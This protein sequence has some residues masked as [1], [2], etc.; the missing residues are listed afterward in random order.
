MISGNAGHGSWLVAP[1][2]Q[3]RIR[4]QEVCKGMQHFERGDL[5]QIRHLIIIR[6]FVFD[7]EMLIVTVSIRSTTLWA[8]AHMMIRL[9]RLSPVVTWSW[10]LW[11]LL[12]FVKTSSSAWGPAHPLTAT[13]DLTVVRDLVRVLVDFEEYNR[14]ICLA[15]GSIR[16]WVSSQLCAPEPWVA[17]GRRQRHLQCRP[18]GTKYVTV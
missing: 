7:R 10:N 4:S 2:S 18:R 16:S 6:T 14:H 8:R 9:G 11:L 17:T 12:S 15:Q 1:E 5:H 3:R 13:L